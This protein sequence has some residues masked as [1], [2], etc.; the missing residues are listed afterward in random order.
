MCAARDPATATTAAAE[1]ETTPTGKMP[2]AGAAAAHPTTAQ[3]SDPTGMEQRF[4]AAV[5]VIRSLPADGP[6]RLST[7][8]RLQV[9]QRARAAG[10]LGRCAPDAAAVSCSAPRPL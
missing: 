1:A 4:Q 3:V 2:T 8:Q 9:R 5:R 7:E 6:F 10:R